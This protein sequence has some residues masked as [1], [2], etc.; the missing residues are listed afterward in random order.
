MTPNSD[1]PTLGEI[2]RRLE[3]AIRQISELA[4]QMRE[5]RVYA[6][7]TY[8]RQD[9]YNANRTADELRVLEAQKDLDEVNRLREVDNNWRRQIMLAVAILSITTLVTIA[10]AISNYMSR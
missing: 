7:Q 9:V 1:P 4:K 8:V 6:N 3:D 5:D 10:I 2:L